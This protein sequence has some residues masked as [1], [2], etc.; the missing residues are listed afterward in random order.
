VKW[1]QSSTDV[2]D[3]DFRSAAKGIGIPYGIYDTQESRFP[4]AISRNFRSG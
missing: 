1:E 4:S 2:N 3:H